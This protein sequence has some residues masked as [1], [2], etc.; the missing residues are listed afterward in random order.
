MTPP[1]LP[2]SELAAGDGALAGFRPSSEVEA[3]GGI[4]SLVSSLTH[5]VASVI[6][7]ATIAT[8]KISLRITVI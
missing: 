5:P 8:G 4:V 3:Y 6:A 2:A 1:E 7:H